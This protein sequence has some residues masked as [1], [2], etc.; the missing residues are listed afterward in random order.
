M[1]SFLSIISRK[2]RNNFMSIV[3]NYT[4]EELQHIIAISNSYKDLARKLGYSNSCSGDT[5]KAL[6]EKVKDFDTSHFYSN[7][8]APKKRNEEN[9][10]IENS[11]ASQSTLR[12]WYTKGEY[13]PYICSVCGQE[14]VWQGK[15]LTL[16]LD[17]INGKNTDDRLENLR[18]VCPNCNQQLET[19]GAKNP[20][21][22]IFAKKFYCIDCGKEISKN[23]TRC[24]ACEAKKRT[25]ALEDME[26]SREELK[27]LIRTTSFISIGKQYNVTDNA[28]RKWCDKYGLPR[29]KSEIKNYSDEEWELI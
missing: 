10:F 26:I 19:T 6:K 14:P 4:N 3:D 16:I 29:K 7:N 11:T 28:I 18:W 22:K 12:R 2:E 8:V 9:I 24:Q 17:H 5:I 1:S 27:Q 21:R 23:S 13:T 20:N 15:D 25:I